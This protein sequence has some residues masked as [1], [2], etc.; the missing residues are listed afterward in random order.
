MSTSASLHRRQR[1]TIDDLVQHPGVAIEELTGRA[2]DDRHA[3]CVGMPM[4][5]EEERSI[6]E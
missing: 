3:G 2:T 6:R 1:W 5:V 4:M